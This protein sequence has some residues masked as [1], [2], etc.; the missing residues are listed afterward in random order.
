[1]IENRKITI[2]HIMS[3]GLNTAR[4]VISGIMQRWIIIPGIIPQTIE[5]SAAI[6]YITCFATLFF[7]V[8]KRMHKMIITSEIAATAKF[9]L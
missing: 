3:V 6:T 7:N 8:N 5:D 9:A 2:E 4:Q 1:M